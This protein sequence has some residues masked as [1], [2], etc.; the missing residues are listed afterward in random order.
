MTMK[1][2]HRIAHRRGAHRTADFTL[3]RLVTD[4]QGLFARMVHALIK[5]AEA[6]FDKRAILERMRNHLTAQDA[7]AAPRQEALLSE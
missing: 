2:R 1:P 4:L 3:A 5:L 6:G 7:V